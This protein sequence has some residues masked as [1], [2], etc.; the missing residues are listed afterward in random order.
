M[1]RSLLFF[2]IFLVAA[3]SFAEKTVVVSATKAIVFLDGAQVEHKATLPL[4]KGSNEFR[5]EG[6]SPKLDRQ[7]IQ[8]SLSQG[9]VVSSFEYS[10]D[11]L[12]Q[13]GQSLDIKKIEDSLN[14]YKK[15]LE[16]LETERKT[17]LTM[18]ELLEK[19]VNH[20]VSTEGVNITSETIDK[21]L[22]YYKQRAEKLASERIQIES[23]TKIINSRITAL[24]Q[25]LKQDGKKDG[26]RSGVLNL[27]IQ[28]TKAMNSDIEIT[29]FTSAAG[30]TPFYDINLTDIS[31][32]M[33][34][35]MNAQVA[36]TTGIDW[37]NIN[38]CLS[39]GMPKKNNRLPNFSTWFLRRQPMMRTEL[40]SVK[41]AATANGVTM[42][43]V[44]MDATTE[45]VTEEEYDSM[46]DFIATTE[47]AL[48]I[49]YDIDLK[50]TILGNGKQ[51]TV[52]L[53]NHKID[54]AEYE[55][56]AAPKLSESVYLCSVLPNQHKLSL[57]NG[58]ANITYANTYYG[59]TYINASTTEELRLTLG[60]DK[61]IALKRE[62]I[63]E[64]SKTKTIGQNKSMEQNWRI[65]VK[66][67]KLQA[68]N[69]T[70]EEPYPISTA[71]EI[72]VELAGNTS[73][74]KK[75]DTE[76]GLLTYQMSLEPGQSKE[77]IIGYNVKYPKDWNINL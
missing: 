8:V 32:P 73:K 76:K 1:K 4:V 13:T 72:Q 20:S 49:K 19:G 42:S 60:E 59:Q 63:A 24:N 9:A 52:G 77:I 12:T 64:L 36:Q 39:T 61:Q 38:L 14:I 35:Q 50:Y 58:N 21:N 22:N 11:Y 15:R 44:T 33:L 27:S 26:Q 16:R 51:Q 69:I 46:D 10:I 66:N 18:A 47:Q 62:K 41:R 70:I 67:N 75:N 6:L 23:Q 54:D 7:S 34:L 48:N 53:L 25:Q 65:I 43:A 2:A 40:Y 30:W 55:Y 29:Y 57:L 31:Q 5:I 56:Y 71:K 17:N 37:N 3:F 45:I 28:V 74:W 68:I